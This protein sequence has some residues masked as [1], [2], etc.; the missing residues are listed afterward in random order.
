MAATIGQVISDLRERIQGIEAS[1]QRSD[2]RYVS[3]GFEELDRILGDR[4][5]KRG[6]LIEWA[7]VGESEGSG[8]ATLA[9]TIAA[10]VLRHDGALMVIDQAGEFYPVAAAELGIPLERT[11]ILRPETRMD[12]L[13]AWEQALRC[14]GVAVTFGW[15]DAI[16]DRLLRRLQSA[17][18]TGGGLGFLLRPPNNRSGPSWAATRI[19]VNGVN[20]RAGLR[21]R[22]VF[23]GP[24]FY[25]P[26]TRGADATPLATPREDSLAR[27]LQVSLTHGETIEVELEH[28]ASDVPLVSELADSAASGG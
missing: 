9:L 7:G 27:R 10:N 25:G 4:G 16:D 15:I 22:P 17:V 12:A 20:W 3:T 11:V 2:T 5:L 23:Y 8:A 18:E 14:P 28:E 21:Q 1:G 13:W 26:K 6:S 19:C 24:V